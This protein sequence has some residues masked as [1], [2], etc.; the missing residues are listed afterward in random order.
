MKFDKTNIEKVNMNLVRFNGE[1]S[2]VMGKVTMP[3]STR[4][5]TVYVQ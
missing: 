4:G 2:T 1:P 5:V 3:L